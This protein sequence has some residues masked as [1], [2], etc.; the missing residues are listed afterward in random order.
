MKFYDRLIQA[1]QEG[2][3]RSSRH[4][5]MN[6]SAGWFFVQQDLSGAVVFDISNVARYIET[7]GFKADSI[8][9]FLPPFE[10]VFLETSF[11][12]RSHVPGTLIQRI[13][14]LAHHFTA[15]QEEYRDTP[16]V[17]WRIFLELGRL[18]GIPFL[19]VGKAFI[20]TWLD[21]QGRVTEA[22]YHHSQQ[23][24]EYFSAEELEQAEWAALGYLK[25]A[26]MA[27]G[28]CHCKNVEIVDGSMAEGA[29]RKKQEKKLGVPLTRYKEL[30]IDPS[31]S[32]KRYVGHDRPSDGEKTHKSLHIVR[33]HFATYTDDKKLF[34]R[35]TGTFWKP[36]H[37]RGSEEIGTVYKD[38][39]VKAS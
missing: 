28:F 2:E 19:P 20:T 39:R 26:Y 5:K 34:G 6:D 7:H 24:R 16:G 3:P 38:Y 21:I 33:G 10:R 18:R 17:N 4:P 35:H 27:I 13:G 12:P 8:P 37:M 30:I 31:M 11:I 29:L 15:G 23:E 36:A 22:K 1:F 14:I 25:A 9:S 32:E